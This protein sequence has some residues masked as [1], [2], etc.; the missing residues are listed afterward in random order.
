VSPDPDKIS[1]PF[2]TRY[3]ITRTPGD[4]GLSIEPYPEVCENGALRATVVASAI[5]LVGGFHT[6]AA[7]GTDATFTSDLSLRIPSPSIPP[8]IDV[9][10]ELLRSG[11]RL[12]T[13]GVTLEAEGR[14]YAY[15]TTTF[16]RIPR[17]PEDAPDLE[18]LSTPLV[19]ARNPLDRP[20]D[21]EVGIAPLPATPGTLALPL[22]P[23]LL[24]PEG[25]M[26]GALVALVVEC[27]ALSLAR[28]ATDR[29]HVVCDLDLRYLAAAAEGPVESRADWIG[30]PDAN[31]IRVELRDA[32]RDHRLTTLALVRVADAPS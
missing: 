14:T 15:G 21:Q 13:T 12:V 23:A 18:S 11:R 22:R 17:P 19:I 31:T 28:E 2:F 1:P 7:A 30:S 9:E 32:G 24:N 29:A 8:R 6:R 3:G 16:A 27:A 26:Q 4:L 5:D 25:V 20:L 10:G